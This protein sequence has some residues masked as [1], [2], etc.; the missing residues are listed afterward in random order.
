MCVCHAGGAPACCRSPG[1]SFTGG[2]EYLAATAPDPTQVP[3][4]A[5]GSWRL[6]APPDAAPVQEA[7]LSC[8]PHYRILLPIVQAPE[9]LGTRAAHSS[10]S[11]LHNTSKASNKSL[12]ICQKTISL[13]SL[14]SIIFPPCSDKPSLNTTETGAGNPK[15]LLMQ[16]KSRFSKNALTKKQAFL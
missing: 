4:A 7:P 15:T 9:L 13:L 6:P 12:P 8:P 2:G 14:S 5:A 16:P 11:A 3:S 10:D 1:A